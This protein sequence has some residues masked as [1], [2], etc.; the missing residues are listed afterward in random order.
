MKMDTLYKCINCG[1]QKREVDT[2]SPM[3][4][5]CVCG[6][7]LSLERWSPEGTLQVWD[8]KV[9]GKKEVMTRMGIFRAGV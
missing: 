1:R 3:P 6:G 5:A 9:Y 7:F 2:V 8:E 4:P